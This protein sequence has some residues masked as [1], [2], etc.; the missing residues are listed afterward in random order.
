MVEFRRVAF[1]KQ[2]KTA[3][4]KDQVVEKSMMRKESLQSR[5]FFLSGK[6]VR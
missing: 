5:K 1:R 3:K 4:K 6:V 2:E